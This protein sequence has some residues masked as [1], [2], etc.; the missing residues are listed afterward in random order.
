M[1][2]DSYL[3][4]DGFRS[5]ACFTLDL[6]AH[7][8]Y[9]WTHRQKMPPFLSHLEQRRF[10][11]RVGIHRILE[12][13]DRFALKG[14]FFVPG[15]VAEDHPELLPRLGSHRGL[16]VTAALATVSALVLAFSVRRSQP[17]LAAGIGVIAPLL[18]LA[19]ASA[20]VDPFDVAFQRFHGGE[21]LVWRT[22]SA[23]TTVAIH[24]RPGSP[25]MRKVRAAG[26][27]PSATCDGVR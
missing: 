18:F 4:P 23:Q 22:E 17:S 25:P 14:T 3:W 7:A 9:L 8:P 15:K 5:A 12:L 6:D 21:T 2:G 26:A 1:S 24:E 13:L 27:F 20:A 11:P 16:I 10:G 19:G